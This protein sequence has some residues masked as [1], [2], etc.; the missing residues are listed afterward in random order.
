MLSSRSSPVIANGNSAEREVELREA[1][2]GNVG[3]NE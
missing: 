1:G 3:L 2:L